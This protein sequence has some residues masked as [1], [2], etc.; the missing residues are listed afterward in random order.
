M[1]IVIDGDFRNP[2]FADLFFKPVDLFNLDRD[3]MQTQVFMDGE[4]VVEV[5]GWW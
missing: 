2:S 1:G 3:E 4:K 5:N